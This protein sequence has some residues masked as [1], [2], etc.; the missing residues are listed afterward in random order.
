MS[1]LLHAAVLYVCE[2]KVHS[3]ILIE[4]VELLCYLVLVFVYVFWL[5]RSHHQAIHNVN[6]F[7]TCSA[8]CPMGTKVLQIDR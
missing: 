6:S 1:L 4:W 7:P 2:Y 5:Y 3:H 8:G